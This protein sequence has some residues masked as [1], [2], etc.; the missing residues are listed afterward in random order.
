[1]DVGIAKTLVLGALL[2]F[3][4]VMLVLSACMT[5]QT[6]F[7]QK[8]S[9]GGRGF[10]AVAPPSGKPGGPT[11]PVPSRGL[12]GALDDS[13]PAA[14][15]VSS[16]GVFGKFCSSDGDPFCVLS[17]FDEWMR[18]KARD[19]R[20]HGSKAWSRSNGLIE[21]RLYEVARLVRQFKSTLSDAGLARIGEHADDDD[22]DDDDDEEE[23]GGAPATGANGIRAGRSRRGGRDRGGGGAVDDEEERKRL[24]RRLRFLKQ[25]ASND[26]RKRTLT[27]KDTWQHEG[28]DVVGGDDGG[29]GGDDE[30]DGDEGRGG[31]G[32]GHG[33]DSGRRGGRGGGPAK[34]PRIDAA[35]SN[36]T[37][38]DIH[39]LDFCTSLCGY[40]RVMSPRSSALVAV[41][42]PCACEV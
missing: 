23:E 12:G 28:D 2:G 24:Q 26:K 10:S 9:S 42:A 36:D 6:P 21:Q 15:A 1:M 7:Q 38:D 34:H 32:G 3:A 27:I 29:G 33:D 18:Q 40:R 16:T 14:V 13:D 4:D 22:D 8:P 25:E 41:S 19:A 30:G 35:P 37:I 39:A 11:P 31:G 20:G 17:A 5:V